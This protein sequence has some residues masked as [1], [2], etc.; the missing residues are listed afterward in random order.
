LGNQKNQLPTFS[1]QIRGPN[2]FGVV[3][4]ILAVRS[5]MSID[6]TIEKQ[7]IVPKKIRLLLKLFWAIL[8]KYDCQFPVAFSCQLG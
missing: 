8:E 1:H 4:N 7:I 3:R 5:I 6:P 2:F